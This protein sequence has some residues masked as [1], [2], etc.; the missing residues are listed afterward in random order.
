MGFLDTLADRAGASAWLEKTPRHVFHAGWIGRH[1]PGAHVI[2]I[3]REGHAVAASIRERA[4]QYPERFARQRRPAYA[5]RTWNRALRATAGVAHRQEQTV[6]RYEDLAR[7]PEGELRRL[8]AEAGLAFDPAMIEPAD[9]SAFIQAHEA[10]KADT[11]GPV[12]ERASRFARAFTPAE[13][14]WVD[15]HLDWAA[16]RRATGAERP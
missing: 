4:R 3:V 8:C 12:A 1:V 9:G 2:H 16:Y 5:V 6:V 15:S 13:Q 11:A 14:A 10:W 7:D